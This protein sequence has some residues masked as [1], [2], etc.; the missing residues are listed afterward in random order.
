MKNILW[1]MRTAVSKYAAVI[2]QIIK[3]DVEIVDPNLKVV[4]GTGYYKNK[5]NKNVSDE[6]HI[7]KMV[8]ETG[9]RKIIINPREHEDCLNCPERPNCTE[10]FDMSAPIKLNGSVIGV[11]GFVCMTES[12]KA[13]IL[14]NYDTFIEF[15]DQIA[16][17]IALKALETEENERHIEIIQFMNEIIAHVEEGVVVLDRNK[18]ILKV[19]EEGR[20]IL[21]ICSDPIENI[22]FQLKSTGTKL[23]DMMEYKVKIDDHVFH[24]IGRVFN[25]NRRDYSTVFIFKDPE[26]LREKAHQLT[27]TKETF[28]LSNII[29]ES[30]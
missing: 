7:Y 19:N 21:G 28:N 20:K 1:K 13:Y 10:T 25:I 22:H 27:V 17:L 30:K 15:L 16:D 23:L 18:K 8:L 24:V 2:S 4:A 12:Q 26:N 9:A 11:I 6:G 3:V 29:G 5:I 14:E